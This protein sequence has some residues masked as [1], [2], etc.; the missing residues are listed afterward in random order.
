MGEAVDILKKHGWAGQ[1]NFGL[2]E[3]PEALA[4]IDQVSANVY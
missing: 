1:D 4:E 2:E 3:W